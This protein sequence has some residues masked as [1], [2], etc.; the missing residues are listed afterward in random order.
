M[1]LLMRVFHDIVPLFY[2]CVI[3]DGHCWPC[4]FTI[5]QGVLY[6]MEVSIEHKCTQPF[7][8]TNHELVCKLLHLK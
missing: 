3:F 1:H 2:E 6:G 4:S 5:F 8:S 7:A